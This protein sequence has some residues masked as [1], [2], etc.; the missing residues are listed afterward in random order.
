M[1]DEI[2]RDLLNVQS[3]GKTVYEQFHRMRFFFKTARLDSSICRT[4]VLTMLENQVKHVITKNQAVRQINI[5]E[6]TIDIARHRLLTPSDLLTCDVVPSPLLFDTNEKS[7][8]VRE[9]ETFL[10]DDDWSYHTHPTMYPLK[11]SYAVNH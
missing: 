6:K 4:K 11:P 1:N 3:T 9:L 5:T 7:V 10:T 2:R 8:L